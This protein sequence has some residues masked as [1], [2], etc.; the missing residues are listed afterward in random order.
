MFLS[1]RL[2]TLVGL[3]VAASSLAV[4]TTAASAASPVGPKQVFVGLING[5]FANAEIRV[6][7]TGPIYPGETGHV[8]PG[9]SVEVLPA[10]STGSTAGYT[11]TKAR[12]IKLSIVRPVS[13]EAGPVS[14]V[15]LADYGVPVALPTSWSL[16]CSGRGVALFLPE[17]TSKTARS[18]TVG[19]SFVSPGVT[20]SH[21]VARPTHL[22]V[23]QIVRL[24]GT[25]FAPAT[26]LA[27][28][29]CSLTHW[30]APQN[31]CLS[32]NSVTVTTSTSGSFV[33]SM[34]A[35]ICPAVSPPTGTER[36]CYIGV[37]QPTGVDTVRL[38]GAARIVVSWP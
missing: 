13:S 21:I 20:P 7:C 4:W 29:E 19:V 8:L 27:L 30:I 25:G 14:G 11:G 35:E 9:Q 38:E 23:N 3:A 34:R 18:A 28:A 26:S 24:T 15:V 6:S 12:D 32:D 16:P 37:R 1:R 2:P 36:T 33:T 17:P 5:K 10:P 31:P 22:M